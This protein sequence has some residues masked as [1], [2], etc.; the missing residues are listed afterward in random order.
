MQKSQ[1]ERKYFAMLSSIFKRG[2]F[3]NE[4]CLVKTGRQTAKKKLFR[5]VRTSHQ[6][7]TNNACYLNSRYPVVQK[8]DDCIYDFVCCD[9]PIAQNA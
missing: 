5:R 1:C 9:F 2:T 3:E 8:L 4:L 6:T 7:R